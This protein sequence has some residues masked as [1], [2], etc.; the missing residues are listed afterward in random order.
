M[1]TFYR[2]LSS[3]NPRDVNSKLKSEKFQTHQTLGT[4]NWTNFFGR[5]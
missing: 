1:R 3:T 5:L 2:Y 4:H